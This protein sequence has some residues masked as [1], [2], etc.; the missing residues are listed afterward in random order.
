MLDLALC[1]VGGV[2]IGHVLTRAYDA[3]VS[4]QLDREL[5]E[6]LKARLAQ[7]KER[8]VNSR[9]E[10]VNGSL[11]LFN[12]ETDEFLGQG[13]DIYELEENVKNKYPNKLFNVPSDQLEPY[14]KD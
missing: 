7:L 9:I 2:V 11:F 1:L 3:Y 5:T 13:K 14:M 12:R 8:I 10:E 6:K 4:T